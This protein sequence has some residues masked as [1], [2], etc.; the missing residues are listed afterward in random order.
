MAETP[1]LDKLRAYLRN[2]T[3]GLVEDVAVVENLLA[4]CWHELQTG[5]G[6]MEGYKLRDRME[7]V[8][9]DP[10]R[11]SFRIERHGGAAL[12]SIYA[13][14]QSWS[15]EIEQGSAIFNQA[16]RRQIGKPNPP[17][18][19]PPIAEE[20][21]Q[22]IVSGMQDPRLNWKGGDEVRVLI[23]NIIPN[24]CPKQTLTGR[25]RR[26][27]TALR[28]QLTEHGWK[29][30]SNQGRFGKMKICKSG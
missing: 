20:I 10:P 30:L 9:W 24:N 28:E 13:E 6:S 22:L 29:Q 5:D 12:G 19:V 11:L 17:L 14:L 3:A 8:R 4:P 27:S 26:F 16:G 2:L 18:K 15:V 25:R 21:A 23:G 1:N 7:E